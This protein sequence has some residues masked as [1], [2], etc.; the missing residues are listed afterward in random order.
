[1]TDG[2]L[3][4]RIETLKRQLRELADRRTPV[5][6]CG[7]DVVQA[8]SYNRSIDAKSGRDDMNA[9]LIRL[10]TERSDRSEPD[11]HN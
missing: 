7:V 4:R 8:M 10:R 5:I 9:E 2:Q 6:G 11:T 1:M 3:T